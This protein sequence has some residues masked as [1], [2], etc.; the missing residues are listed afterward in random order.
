MDA[1]EEKMSKYLS[2][3]QFP[4]LVPQDS[5]PVAVHDGQHGQAFALIT[6]VSE[7]GASF[8]AGISY[9]VGASLLLRISF[10][11]DAEPFVT[12]GKVVWCR[13]EERKSGSGG[14]V[15]G[16][17]F[18]ILEEEQ[19]EQ[20]RTILKRPEFQVVFRPQRQFPRLVPKES[21]PVS[22]HDSSGGQT[23]GSIINI[24]EGGASLTTGQSY[25]VG[26]TLL[27]RITFDSDSEPFATEA[28]V[29]W[30][31]EKEGSTGSGGFVHGVEFSVSEEEQILRLRE[32]LKRPQFK[33]VFRPSINPSER[34][35]MSDPVPAAQTKS[36]QGD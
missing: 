20:F 10:D 33:V 9:A 11:R 24:S 3:R 28:K 12:E 35:P 4:R 16:V 27:L 6:N 22:V 36:A 29:A 21:I 23:T 7:A 2:N 13:E 31:D 8:A 34:P 17:Q 1:L 19:L 32:I 15:H 26:A 25:A 30:G 18:S 14:F 5:I